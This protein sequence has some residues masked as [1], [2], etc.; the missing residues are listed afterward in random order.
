MITVKCERL[1][2]TV[3]S[4]DVP[5]GRS[6]HRIVCI[7]D[8]IFVIGG[9]VQ[10]P[11]GLEVV[12]EVWV[13]NILAKRWRRLNLKNSPFHLALSACALVIG[14]RI[15]IHGGT[16]IPFAQDINNTI[17]EIDVVSEEC[18]EHPCL[19]KDG[20][21]SNIPEATYGHTLT[22]VRLSDRKSQID[23]GMLIKVG[24]ARG[25]PYSNIISAFS[26]AT[27]SWEKLF[28]GS[29]GESFDDFAPRY[30]HDAV[31]WRDELYIIGGTNFNGSLPFWPMPVFNI[32][33]RTFRY[34]NFSGQC[35]PPTRYPCSVHFDNCL[36]LP[37]LIY[38]TG[39]VTGPH[40]ILNANIYAFDLE[41]LTF[42]IVGKQEFP[43]FF[44]DLAAV[45]GR[46]EFYSFG[47]VRD[48]TRVNH[49]HRFQVG[50]IK[51]P[52]LKDLCWL[53]LTDF[54]RKFYPPELSSDH[55]WDSIRTAAEPLLGLSN[56]SSSSSSERSERGCHA[57]SNV[58]VTSVQG[59]LAF[60]KSILSYLLGNNKQFT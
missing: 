5:A 29:N 58:A 12:G 43:T 26:F 37:Q 38:T 21:E 10:L 40:D 11:T 22:Y 13:Y 23:G 20:K 27:H 15:F 9:Y 25:A 56:A 18:K 60:T 24:G 47:G 36:F 7:D 41:K 57:A 42:Q 17:I 59:V 28:G 48:E 14:K 54:L 50:G 4:E 39:G 6:G 34:I 33:Q 35:P 46:N 16:G 51:P 8:E 45:P 53:H 30:R 55:L 49:L 52:C 3:K 32:K 1:E 44:H 19:P 31:F 2:P